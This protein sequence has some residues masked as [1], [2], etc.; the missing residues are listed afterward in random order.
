MF[1]NTHQSFNISLQDYDQKKNTAINHSIY[2]Y[3][4]MA[5]KKYSHQSFNI[6]LQ[7]YD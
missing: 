1:S 7:D 6:S 3:K 4:T 5:K 2:H